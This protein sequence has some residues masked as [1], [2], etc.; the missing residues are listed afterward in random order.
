MEERTEL[1]HKALRCRHERLLG[2]P[3]D[4]SPIHW[5]Y[6]GLARLAK[7]EPID[8]LLF[9]GYSSISLGYAGLYECCVAMTG[10]SHTDPEVTPFALEILQFM[11]NKCNKWAAEENIGY[12]VYGTPIEST[13]YHFARKLRERFG[14]IKDVTD[15]NYISNSYH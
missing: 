10:K 7:G 1:C 2:T 4:I 8:K 15:H 12:S 6:G 13:T 5:Q 9:G 11:N 14:V 3:S